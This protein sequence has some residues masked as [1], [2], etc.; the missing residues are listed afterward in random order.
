MYW[1]RNSS[2]LYTVYKKI[3]ISCAKGFKL[4]MK[5]S[6]LIEKMK[7]CLG[8]YNRSINFIVVM[9]VGHSN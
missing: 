2:K 7:L 5:N 1:D 9:Q 8:H 3:K 4:A 6:S